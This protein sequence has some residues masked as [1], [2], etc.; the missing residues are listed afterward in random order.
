M[1]A[2]AA[3]LSIIDSAMRLVAE[4]HG[5]AGQ[6]KQRRHDRAAAR[7]CNPPDIFGNRQPPSDWDLDA[8]DADAVDEQPRRRDDERQQ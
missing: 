4:R 8:P 1:P 7:Q 3:A 2:Q 5:G 6:I